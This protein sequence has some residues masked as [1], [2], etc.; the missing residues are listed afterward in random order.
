MEATTS[1]NKDGGASKEEPK[2]KKVDPGPDEAGSDPSTSEESESSEE[3]DD[4][5]VQVQTMEPQDLE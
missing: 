1:E 4:P 3:C 2:E 5:P